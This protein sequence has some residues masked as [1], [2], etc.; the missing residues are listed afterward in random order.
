MA[1]G[2]PGGGNEPPVAARRG[3]I[4]GMD[5]WP[6]T[7]RLPPDHHALGLHSTIRAAAPLSW[8]TVVPAQLSGYAASPLRSD[9]LISDTGLSLRD[10]PS[11]ELTRLVP[12]DVRSARPWRTAPGRGA[13]SRRLRPAQAG[14]GRL[15]PAQAGAGGGFSRH[16]VRSRSMAQQRTSSLRANATMA[17]FLRAL[18]RLRRQ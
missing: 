17:C 11:Y 7:T 3:E 2:G 9:S 1:S 14:S 18:P 4:F 10:R 8:L 5:A 13:R 12:S 6:T 16:G 15:R